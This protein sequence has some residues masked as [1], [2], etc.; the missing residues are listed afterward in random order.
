M[1]LRFV[2]DP[3]NWA[4]KSAQQREA[5]VAAYYTYQPPLHQPVVQLNIPSRA[6]R[7]PGK[8]SIRGSTTTRKSSTKR[9]HT[10]QTNRNKR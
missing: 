4:N 2:H 7:K 1:F 9:I 5:I 8:T 3:H 6:G 10:S